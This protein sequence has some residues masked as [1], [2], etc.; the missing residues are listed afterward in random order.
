[1][2]EEQSPLVVHDS[3]SDTVQPAA[4]AQE[5]VGGISHRMEEHQ[6]GPLK[7]ESLNCDLVP[8]G[9][10]RTRDSPIMPLDSGLGKPQ[11]LCVEAVEE[12]IRRS[13]VQPRR[14]FDASITVN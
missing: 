6:R 9:W 13:R 2:S 3:E 12:A 4:T 7:T 1:M 11:N 10:K 14:Q 8:E 5:R